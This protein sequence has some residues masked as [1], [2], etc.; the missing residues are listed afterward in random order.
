MPLCTT[1]S[2]RAE[3]KS[4]TGRDEH[5]VVDRTRGPRRSDERDRQQHDR[6]QRNAP[7]V[8]AARALSGADASSTAAAASMEPTP[9]NTRAAPIPVCPKVIATIPTMLTIA[10]NRL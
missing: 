6:D 4:A 9:A 10:R 8:I 7:W 3:T 1:P 2:G 5:R